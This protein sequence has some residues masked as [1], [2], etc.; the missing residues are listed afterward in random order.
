MNAESKKKLK[1]QIDECLELLKNIYDENQAFEDDELKGSLSVVAH[2]IYMLL[3]MPDMEEPVI[4]EILPQYKRFLKVMEDAV[5]EK[6][7]SDDVLERINSS[8]GGLSKAF[9]RVDIMLEKELKEL[10]D[11]TKK[12]EDEAVRM[13]LAVSRKSLEVY[14]TAAGYTV[15]DEDVSTEETG[16]Y[17]ASFYEMMPGDLINVRYLI[18]YMYSDDSPGWT[19][20]ATIPVRCENSDMDEAAVN[21]LINECNAASPADISYIGKFLSYEKGRVDICL[22]ADKE[23]SSPDDIDEYMRELRKETA[24]V[25]VRIG[26]Y[27]ADRYIDG[28]DRIIRTRARLFSV[29]DPETNP[30][31]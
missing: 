11:R 3:N 28:E 19:F 2:D 23:V 26:R 10:E 15:A 27:F 14:L 20:S 31:K 9:M 29:D 1:W 13:T 25:Y 16:G 5:M 17:M 6:E 18:T 30:W 7:L 12:L 22:T 21:D 8:L 4:S 24:E